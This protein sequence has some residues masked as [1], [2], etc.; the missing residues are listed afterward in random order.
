[1][2]SN[3]NN[4][5]QQSRANEDVNPRAG[6]HQIKGRGEHTVQTGEITLAKINRKS[7][8]S[9]QQK[10]LIALTHC[11]LLSNYSEY[12]AGFRSLWEMR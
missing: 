10:S 8:I 5:F 4:I 1:M 12:G 11:D 7:V 9:E 3:N 6:R 2:A